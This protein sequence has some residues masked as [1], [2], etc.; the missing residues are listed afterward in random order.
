VCAEYGV[1]CRTGVNDPE[2]EPERIEFTW[3]HNE[4]VEEGKN[5]LFDPSF[6]EFGGRTVEGQNDE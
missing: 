6:G 4:G 2:K 1:E 3:C 5:L